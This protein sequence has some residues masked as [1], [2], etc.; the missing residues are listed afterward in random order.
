MCGY[1]IWT[2]ELEYDFWA[3]FKDDLRV[4]VVMELK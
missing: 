2:R 4:V 3:A 1:I